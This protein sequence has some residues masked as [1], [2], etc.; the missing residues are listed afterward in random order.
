MNSA[1]HDVPKETSGILYLL[2][3]VGKFRD[4]RPVTSDRGQDSGRMVAVTTDLSLT[5][6]RGLV[7]AVTRDLG[8]ASINKNINSE[9]RML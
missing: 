6:D 8:L 2:K 4:W 5:K 7:E 1:E 3:L 9:S